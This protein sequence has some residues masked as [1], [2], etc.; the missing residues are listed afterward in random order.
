M[1]SLVANLVGRGVVAMVNAAGKLQRLQVKLLAGEVKDGI[2]HFES[3]GFTSKP[4]PGA[5]HLTFFLDGDRS[6]GITVVVTDRRYR[7]KGLPDGGVAIYDSAG[8]CIVLSADGQI[9]VTAPTK[10]VIDSP[11]VEMTGSLSVAQNIVAQGDISDQGGKSMRADR[12][13]YDGHD[14]DLPG[15]GKSARP[16]QLQGE[17]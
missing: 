9:T 3:Y 7:I 5:E 1:V 4:L 8:A 13:V 15:G 17:S 11:M 6:H 2:E 14:H 12:E 10:V 16:N